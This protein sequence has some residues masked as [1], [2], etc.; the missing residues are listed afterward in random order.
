MALVVAAPLSIPGAAG[1]AFIALA[2]GH[3]ASIRTPRAQLRWRFQ[4]G[5]SFG[6]A[7]TQVIPMIMAGAAVVYES[8]LVLLLCAAAWAAST[9]YFG[10]EIDRTWH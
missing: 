2:V 10:R 5:P 3:K 9:W 7:L 6:D 1:A 4:T 8:P